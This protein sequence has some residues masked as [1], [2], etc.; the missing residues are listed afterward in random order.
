[1]L[2]TW[3]GRS[4]AQKARIA[5][6]MPL[7]RFSVEVILWT[8]AALALVIGVMLAFILIRRFR[9][10]AYFR[11]RD[12]VR[13]E[14]QPVIERVLAGVARPHPGSL[15]DL[16]RDLL[17][18]VLLA[19]LEEDPARRLAIIDFFERYGFVDRRLLRLKARSAWVRAQAALSLGRMRSMEGILGLVDALEDPASDVRLAA[20]RSLTLLASPAAAL[21]LIQFLLRGAPGVP[22]STMIP[23]LAVCCR[24]SAGLLVEVLAT[25]PQGPPRI[26]AAAALAEI[27]TPMIRGQLEPFLYDPE[28]EVRGRIAMA[29]GKLRD[30]AA[31]NALVG[32]I[33]DPVWFVR[34]RAVHA[35]GEIGDWRALPALLKAVQDGN[36]QVRS[37]VAHVLGQH[38]WVLG[39]VIESVKK[40]G[41]RYALQALLSELE[42]A[43]L[44]WRA[45]GQ[46]HSSEAKARSD[47]RQV[48]IAAIRAGALRA[49]LHAIETFPDPEIVLEIA[50]LLRRYARAEDRP[51][52]EV[53]ARSPGLAP[54][55][56]RILRAAPPSAVEEQSAEEPRPVES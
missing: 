11:A 54:P 42:R 56:A 49:A 24:G 17:E 50:E 53:L 1:M 28:P 40:S 34:L 25:A 41:D 33:D 20:V 2:S 27:S 52:L 8:S 23:A 14:L 16:E 6:P 10:Q 46:L 13:L 9:R 37:Q 35:L 31:V 22:T 45:I 15:S 30:W 38:E 18:T 43:G 44:I 4:F 19:R 47:A 51:L 12:Q 55:V 39:S 5:K 26:T 36:W 21:P 7:L 32:L 48:L 29:I 3:C